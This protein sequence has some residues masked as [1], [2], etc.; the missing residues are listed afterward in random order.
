[1]SSLS[2]VKEPPEDSGGAGKK[3]EVDFGTILRLAKLPFTEN[4]LQGKS[5]SLWDFSPS[6]LGWSSLKDGELVNLKGFG[7]RTLWTSSEIWRDL[8]QKEYAEGVDV[9]ARVKKRLSNVGFHKITWLMPMSLSVAAQVKVAAAE[10]DKVLSKNILQE[11]NWSVSKL[12]RFTVEVSLDGRKLKSVRILK[13][14]KPWAQVRVRENKGAGSTGA[15]ARR[16]SG[17]PAPPATA[18]QKRSRGLDTKQI[19]ELIERGLNAAGVVGS[20]FERRIK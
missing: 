10:G 15:W 17:K 4:G 20:F 1:M 3:L 13:A 19:A 14:G 8:F 18:L 2:A 11:K 16:T 9:E 5:G 6:G 7:V 12:G